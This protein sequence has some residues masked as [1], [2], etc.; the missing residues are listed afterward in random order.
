MTL[1]T[2]L[3]S[4]FMPDMALYFFTCCSIANYYLKHNYLKQEAFTISQFLWSEI[5]DKQN[6]LYLN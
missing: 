2:Y 6:C 4:M 5:R 3:Y 1:L